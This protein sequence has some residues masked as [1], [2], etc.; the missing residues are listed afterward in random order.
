MREKSRL[1]DRPVQSLLL[2][3]FVQLH[4]PP[5]LDDADVINSA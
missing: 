5:D 3:E 1:S 4:S 2:D